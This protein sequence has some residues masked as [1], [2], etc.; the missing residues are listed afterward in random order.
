M[1]LLY[2]GE[3]IGEIMTNRSLTLEECFE[4]LNVDINEMEDENT[5]KYDYDL[6]EME[7]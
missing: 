4:L 2:D 1:K 3:V 5:P 6:F 7:Y